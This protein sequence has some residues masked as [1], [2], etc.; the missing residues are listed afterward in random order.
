M[1][2]PVLIFFFWYLGEKYPTAYFTS[3]YGSP[4]SVSPDWDIFYFQHLCY[5][6]I[7]LHHLQK[8]P[9][10]F[11]FQVSKPVTAISCP[12][13]YPS[14]N[15]TELWDGR[16]EFLHFILNIT[17]MMKS[18]DSQLLNTSITH[19]IFFTPKFKFKLSCLKCPHRI[20]HTESDWRAPVSIFPTLRVSSLI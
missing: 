8:Y 11:P 18:W 14:E 3:P 2:I 9:F 12:P 4:N 6:P 1:P 5:P 17:H 10:F 7:L 19:P 13:S 15:L 20:Q 16:G